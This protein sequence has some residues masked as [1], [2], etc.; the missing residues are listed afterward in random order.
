MQQGKKNIPKKEI[1]NIK[2]QKEVKF[3]SKTHQ[4]EKS[5]K[6]CNSEQVHLCSDDSEQAHLCSDDS[7]Q[8]VKTKRG[9][10]PVSPGGGLK[11]GA[12]PGV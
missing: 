4:K 3:Q 5:C 2:I 10:W 9:G 11:G 12:R 1:N 6:S 7:E 8:E